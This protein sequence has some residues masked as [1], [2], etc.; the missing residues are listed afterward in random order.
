MLG[1]VRGGG[2]CGYTVRGEPS[3]IVG[4]TVGIGG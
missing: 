3:T 2:D 4:F 1:A